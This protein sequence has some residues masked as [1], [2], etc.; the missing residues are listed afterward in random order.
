MAIGDIYQLVSVGKAGNKAAVNVYHYR[1]TSAHVQTFEEEDLAMA[2]RDQI[3]V[4]LKDQLSDF[5]LLELIRC[6]NI[7]NINAPF[8]LAVNETGTVVQQAGPNQSAVIFSWKTLLRG[9]SYRGRNYIAGIPEGRITGSVVDAGSLALLQGIADDMITLDPTP[10]N[11]GY[12]L[13]V[14]SRKLLAF[15]PVTTGIAKAVTGVVRNRRPA[16]N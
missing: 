13:G 11:G 9:P 2:W 4:D 7:G 14:Y 6:A 10:T 3:W 16:A 5:Y 1:Q 12:E 15:N 8:E